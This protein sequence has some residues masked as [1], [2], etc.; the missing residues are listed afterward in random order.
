M[1]SGWALVF[2]G[3]TYGAIKVSAVESWPRLSS[4]R[5]E[6]D[7]QQVSRGGFDFSTLEHLL[8]SA[9]DESADADD[10]NDE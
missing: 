10:E 6:A 1:L 9:N 4:K 3:S 8:D 2:A 7:L 5:I